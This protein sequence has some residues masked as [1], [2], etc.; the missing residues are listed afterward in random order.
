MIKGRSVDKNCDPVSMLLKR[1]ENNPVDQKERM[2]KDNSTKYSRLQK[3]RLN[4]MSDGD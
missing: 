3:R 4:T 1:V 2:G